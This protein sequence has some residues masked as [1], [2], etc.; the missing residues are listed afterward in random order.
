M[1]KEE[2]RMKNES[3]N[4]RSKRKDFRLPPSAFCLNGP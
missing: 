1:K 2:Y 4:G 3:I